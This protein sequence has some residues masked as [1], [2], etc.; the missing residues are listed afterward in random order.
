MKTVVRTLLGLLVI[1]SG[2]S[3]GLKDTSSTAASPT[4]G[5]IAPADVQRTCFTNACDLTSQYCLLVQTSNGTTINSQCINFLPSMTKNC[6]DSTSNAATNVPECG[7]SV[8][9]YQ[10]NTQVIVVCTNNYQ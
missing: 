4:S 5:S 7:Y 1:V 6:T 2:A 9:C 3:C 10:N 8:T